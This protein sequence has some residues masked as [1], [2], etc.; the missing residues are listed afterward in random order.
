MVYHVAACA[1]DIVELD[2][3]L[4]STRK[5]FDEQYSQEHM[6]IILMRQ[7]HP[8]LGCLVSASRMCQ[9]MGYLVKSQ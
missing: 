2:Y 5:I 8:V 4:Q 9:S 6:T 7:I 3:R 1:I